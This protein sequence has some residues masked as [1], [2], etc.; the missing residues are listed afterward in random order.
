MSAYVDRFA[1][2]SR[3]EIAAKV[4]IAEIAAKVGIAEIAAKVGIPKEL[5][6]SGAHYCDSGNCEVCGDGT[7]DEPEQRA[8]D[9][10]ACFAQHLTARMRALGWDQAQ[11]Q[12]RAG[13]SAHVAAKAVNGTGCDLGIA[14]KIAA[15]VGGYLATMIGPYMC[16]TC[17]GDGR[18]GFRCLECGTETRGA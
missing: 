14:G 3:A 18:P 11:L 15:V 16:G 17:G 5:P 12:E 6:V 2:P 10:L 13:I 8:P 7:G 1:S 4:G 9:A